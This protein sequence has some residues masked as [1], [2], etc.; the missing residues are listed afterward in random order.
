MEQTLEISKNGLKSA[1]PKGRWLITFYGGDFYITTDP[2]IVVSALINKD[3]P[4]KP[5]SKDEYS[6][7]M[8]KLLNNKTN[9]INDE[10]YII[11]EVEGV[12]LYDMLD[13][14]AR[15]DFIE[16]HHLR[17]HFEIWGKPVSSRLLSDKLIKN[18]LYLYDEVKAHLLE[19]SRDELIR[20]ILSLV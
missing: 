15:Q 14:D 5:F 12:N 10:I 8:I 9:Y 20:S 3:V 7:D 17:P 1:A 16:K 4:I 11:K 13:P 18:N 2:A 19:E 6:F